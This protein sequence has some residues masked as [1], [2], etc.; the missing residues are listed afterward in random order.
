MNKLLIEGRLGKDAEV[1]DAKA[2]KFL[3]LTIAE[4]QLVGKEKKTFWYDVICFNYNENLVQYYKKGSLL[5]ITGQLTADVETGK[6]GVVRCRR[7]IVADAIDFLS[8]GK[9]DSSEAQTSETEETKNKS[10]E[11]IQTTAVPTDVDNSDL[12]F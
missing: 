2:G 1:R 11:P 10:V 12:P 6:D 9:S 7:K 8:G 5:F 4:N 3:S